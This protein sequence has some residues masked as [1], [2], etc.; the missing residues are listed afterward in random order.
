MYEQLSTSKSLP[1]EWII[2][3]YDDLHE[4]H[5]I[6]L[7]R[8]HLH[9]PTVILHLLLIHGDLTWEV[10]TINHSV[11]SSCSVLHHY[12]SEL[13]DKTA[14]DLMHTLNDSIVCSGNYDEQFIE[15]NTRLGKRDAIFQLSDISAI[16]QIRDISAESTLHSSE[17]Y[18]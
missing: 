15:L 16:F 2:H 14:L 18:T 11:S 12:P 8:Q 7:K 13:T 1:K 5:C 9:I 3:K 17:W 6:K 4:I 10:H